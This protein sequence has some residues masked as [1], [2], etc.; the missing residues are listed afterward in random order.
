MS[1]I[2]KVL[3]VAA[4]RIEAE[5]VEIA[6]EV[7]RLEAEIERVA[8]ER[9]TAIREIGPAFAEIE[10]LREEMRRYLPA[11]EALEVISGPVEWYTGGVATLEGYRAALKEQP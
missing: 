6:D 1:D 10:R 4:D 7:A 8:K 2:V 5:R 3:R 11:L 9:D